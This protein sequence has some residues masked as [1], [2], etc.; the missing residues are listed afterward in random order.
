[1]NI[2][3]VV[4]NYLRWF[5]LN[6]CKKMLRDIKQSLQASILAGEAARAKPCLIAT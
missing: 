6:Q 2:S 4:S 1:M 5:E 3:Q